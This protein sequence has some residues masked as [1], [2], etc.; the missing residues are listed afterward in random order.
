MSH[1]VLLL[2]STIVSYCISFKC[3]DADNSCGRCSSEKRRRFHFA[4][5]FDD[6]KY[7]YGRDSFDC[8]KKFKYVTS[9]PDINYL[10]FEI[11][12]CDTH[13]TITF[14]NT[15]GVPT[16]D[17]NIDGTLKTAAR[18][19]LTNMQ[20]TT[21][22]T[23]AFDA[24]QNHIFTYQLSSFDSAVHKSIGHH[25]FHVYGANELFYANINYHR[26]NFE[27]YLSSSY[28]E[29]KACGLCGLFDNNPSNDLLGAD[30]TNF[31]LPQLHHIF[32]DRQVQSL[33]NFGLKRKGIPKPEINE[34]LS[35][36]D[37]FAGTYLC[38]INEGND[39]YYCVNWFTGRPEV[40]GGPPISPKTPTNI[41]SK[42]PTNPT[43]IPSKSP[44]NPT[45]IPS[46]SPTNLT[47]IP[48]KTPTNPTNMPSKSPFEA[49]TTTPPDPT[50]TAP[51]DET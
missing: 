25:I 23:Y 35:C 5:T 43:N 42:S 4:R 17:I 24:T 6:I 28:F 22:E 3:P 44:T 41:P 7:P 40:T 50:N 34:I 33:F 10:P 26:N 1:S 36:V 46:K 16:Y 39:E 19:T 31:V 47:N 27:I 29:S 48:S 14:F 32:S 18:N 45:N 30:N 20:L 15:L 37:T 11:C 49:T 12:G 8:L 21:P 13:L 51:P 9:C 38:D 2:L